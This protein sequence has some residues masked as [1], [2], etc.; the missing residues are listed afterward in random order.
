M[1]SELVLLAALAGL[2]SCQATT[3]DAV[4]VPHAGEPTSGAAPRAARR[5]APADAAP[6]FALG[7][8]QACARIGGRVHCGPLSQSRPLSAWPPLKGIEDAVDL[9][10]ADSFGCV[11]TA[12]G[13][14]L[15]FGD[16]YA[17]QLGAGVVAVPNDEAVPVVGVAGARRVFVGP[18]HA[19]AIVEDGR[20]DCW[21][22]NSSGQTGGEAEYLSDAVELNWPVR[23]AGVEGVTEL[24]L[25]RESTCALDAQ[26]RVSCWGAP[27][28]PGPGKAPERPGKAAKRG[29]SNEYQ[30]I[31][32]SSN[33][34]FCGLRQGEVSCWGR[35]EELT[36]GRDAP[37]HEK[38]LPTAGLGRVRRLRLGLGYG[39]AL[40]DRGEIVCWGQELP[41]EAPA[42]EG[43]DPFEPHAV[44]GLPPAIDVVMS[45]NAACAV[46]AGH[47]VYCWGDG[48][49][50]GPKGPEARPVKVLVR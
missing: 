40:H 1:R 22:N 6:E 17:G 43:V 33:G 5:A 50:E 3:S 38:P 31:S 24:A 32:A 2:A 42:A 11:V 8:S 39:C 15:C 49:G 25:G 21:G 35:V 48:L 16:N 41:G 44:A 28:T 19:C 4:V 18:Y 14:V 29:G 12:R 47:E 37:A 23:V 36:F 20:V 10:L 27:L 34:V 13:G 46:S 45:Q 9:A 7:A 30:A 26:G